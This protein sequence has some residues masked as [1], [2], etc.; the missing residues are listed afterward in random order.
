MQ[1][2]A[3]VSAPHQKLVVKVPE[4]G[5]KK[6]PPLMALVTTQPL[7][8]SRASYP[9]PYG[10][11]LTFVLPQPFLGPL[12]LNSIV[13]TRV[14]SQPTSSITRGAGA[15][16]GGTALIYLNAAD[17]TALVAQRVLPFKVVLSYDDVTLKVVKLEL[18]RDVSAVT[19]T[20]VQRLVVTLAQSVPAASALLVEGDSSG[21]AH[22][23]AE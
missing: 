14:T 23:P 12:F 9:N 18:V 3:R 16:Q 19:A 1:R 4:F 13:I 15:T 20:L 7:P 21:G 17:F 6:G 8:V 10:N 2:R 11:T 22:P 5:S